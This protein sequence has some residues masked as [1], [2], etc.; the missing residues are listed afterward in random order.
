MQILKLTDIKSI[1]DY[2]SEGKIGVIPTDTLYGL[3]GLALNPD[4][5]EKIFRLRKRTPTKPMIILISSLVDLKLF[6][7]EID[8]QTRAILNKIWPNPVSVI[9][10]LQESEFA[11][12]DRGTKTLAFRVPKHTALIKILKQ[13][14]P[15]VAPSANFEGQP[16]ALTID[17]AK[18][19]FG[20]QVDFF[21]SEGKIESKPS[22]LVQLN[23]GKLDVIRQGAF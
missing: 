4:V 16:P 1:I 20:D 21:V 13:T 7:I 17:E 10:P 5:V 11:Y 15:L 12:L 14:G 18:K 23:Q 8:D 6:N 2:L 9:L 19:Y 3:V 22:T